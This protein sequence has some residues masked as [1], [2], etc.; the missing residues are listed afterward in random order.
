MVANNHMWLLSTCNVAGVT[1][2]PDFK[3]YLILVHWNLSSHV[4]LVATHIAQHGILLHMR[5]DAMAGFLS[6]APGSSLDTCY[7]EI[8]RSISFSAMKM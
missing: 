4:W 2:E 6:D 5:A 8:V 7:T 1:K 3:F